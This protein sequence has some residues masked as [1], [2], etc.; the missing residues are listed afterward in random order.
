MR[1]CFWIK[2]FL[3]PHTSGEYKTFSFTSQSERNFV[4]CI[5]NSS[6]FWWYWI[7]ISDGWHITS[8]EFEFF[9]LPNSFDVK[10]VF[11]LSSQLEK[12]LEETKRFI[13][14][15]QTEYEYKHK[16]CIFEIHQIDDYIN[17][18]YGLTET[19]S[20]YIKNFA[21]PYRTS[22]GVTK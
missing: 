5:L 3:S 6:L 18:L 22:K 11:K 10:K 15:K 17:S 1:A 16:L 21:L 2:V 9:K 8:K 20:S 7:C 4:Y 19:E 13:G 14:S 12:K